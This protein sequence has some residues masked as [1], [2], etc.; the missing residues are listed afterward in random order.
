MLSCSVSRRTKTA[1]KED[2]GRKEKKER[3]RNS[4]KKEKE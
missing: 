2:D 3:S 4:Q 1:L